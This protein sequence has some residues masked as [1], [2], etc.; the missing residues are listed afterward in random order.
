MYKLFNRIAL[1]LGTAAL[2]A[3]GSAS[4]QFNAIAGRDYTPLSPA[5]PRISDSPIEIVE[6]FAYGCIHCFHLEPKLEKWKSALAKD[7]K[8]V[9]MPTP[10]PTRGLDSTG[11]F[12][13]LE[14]MGQ[15]DRLHYKIFEAVNNENV[16]LGNPNVRDQWL[17][18]NGIDV[19]KYQEVE[20]SFAVQNKIRAA[21]EYPQKYRIESTPTLVVNG[22]YL[23]VNQRDSDVTFRVLDTLIANERAAAPPKAPAA[24]PA[25]AP[26]APAKAPAK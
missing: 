11:I 19:K 5:Q 18:K 17:A 16:M 4:A 6:F 8:L 24:I 21:R 14:A 2:L 1:T 13:T 7:V 9:R 22:K 10:F 12:Y 3:A 26:A 23:V 25:K 20:Q 15:L